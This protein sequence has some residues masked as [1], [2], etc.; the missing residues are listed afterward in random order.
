MCVLHQDR[1]LGI[2]VNNTESYVSH[3]KKNDR[4]GQ[5]Q[6]LK[7]LILATQEAGIRRIMVQSQPRQK[8]H[9][10][11]SQSV[12]GHSGMYLSFQLY[13]EAQIGSWSRLA[14]A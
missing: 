6:W 12:A 13:R 4:C 7:P 14:Q 8:V 2:E 3:R 1:P 5:R 9:K 11:P 10:T